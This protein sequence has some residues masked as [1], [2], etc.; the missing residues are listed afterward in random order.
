MTYILGCSESIVALNISG[1]SLHSDGVLAHASDEPD[2]LLC[3]QHSAA[4]Q[5]NALTP[6]HLLTISVEPSGSSAVILIISRLVFG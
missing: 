4:A 1:N 5:R 3:P 6:S 2:A